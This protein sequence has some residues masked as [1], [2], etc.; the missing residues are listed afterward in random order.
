M[1]Y[2]LQSKQFKK[3]EERRGSKTKQIHKSERKTFQQNMLSY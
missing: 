3:K 2:M 1:S